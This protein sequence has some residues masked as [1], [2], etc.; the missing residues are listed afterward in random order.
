MQEKK[1]RVLSQ[2][3][4]GYSYFAYFPLSIFPIFLRVTDFFFNTN[5]FLLNMYCSYLLLLVVHSLPN[6]LL[7]LFVH[8]GLDLYYCAVLNFWSFV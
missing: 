5:L 4:I 7:F 8:R 2:N 3:F 1:L 6:F